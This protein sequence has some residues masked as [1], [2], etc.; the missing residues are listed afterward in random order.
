MEKGYGY[1][2]K[3]LMD[4]VYEM[5][6]KLGEKE[7]SG[8]CIYYTSDLMSFLLGTE[9]EEIQSKLKDFPAF[10][11][12]CIDD[13]NIEY[14]K[15]GRIGIKVFKSGI[16]KIM[17]LN[18]DRKFLKTLIEKVRDRNCSIEDIKQV[19]EAESSKY[20]CIETEGDEFQYV[21]YFEDSGIDEY[22]YCFTFDAMGSYYHR[23]TDY[24]FKNMVSHDKD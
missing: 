6:L 3:N 21:V 12:S 19:F 4:S 15:D 1:L 10:A 8:I 9:E 14:L 18:S 20:C 13:V 2:L 7:S 23:F 5:M 17:T 24:D 11:K 22:K 16:D